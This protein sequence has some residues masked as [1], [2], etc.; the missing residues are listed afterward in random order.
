MAFEFFSTEFNHFA[1]TTTITETR[2]RVKIYY[3]TYPCRAYRLAM[4]PLCVIVIVRPLLLFIIREKDGT[5]NRSSPGRFFSIV[6]FVY[7]IKYIVLYDIIKGLVYR[8]VHSLVSCQLIASNETVRELQSSSIHR[9]VNLSKINLWLGCKF[10]R[11][12][13]K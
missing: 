12:F 3:K 13:K 6:I 5:P 10:Y 2:T 9:D 7:N 4:S 1:K 8:Q 11:L